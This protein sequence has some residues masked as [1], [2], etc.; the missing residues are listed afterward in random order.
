MP[1]RTITATLALSGGEDKNLG[2]GPVLAAFP[3]PAKSLYVNTES[4]S[5]GTGSNRAQK[6]GLASFSLTG[7]ASVTFDLT[8]FPGPFANVN[9]SLVKECIVDNASTDATNVLEVGNAASNPWLSPFRGTTP[10]VACDP[11]AAIRLNS[12]IV[13]FAVSG[14]NKSIKI[15]NTGAGTNAANGNVLVIGEGT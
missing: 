8:A 15:T 14:T 6:V 5:D 11:G 3:D 9:F 4:L 13:G 12:P 2:T 7:G 10:R 1:L